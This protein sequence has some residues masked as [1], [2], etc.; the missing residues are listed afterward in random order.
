MSIFIQKLNKTSAYTVFLLNNINNK[1]RR[2]KNKREKIILLKCIIIHYF[3]KKNE[4]SVF[5]KTSPEQPSGDKIVEF[6][7]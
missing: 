4:Y 6:I 2:N 1:L 3:Y 5:L 7:R